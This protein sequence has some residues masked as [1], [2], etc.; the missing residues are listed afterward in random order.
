MLCN[1]L[2]TCEKLIRNDIFTNH[3]NFNASVGEFTDDF[4]ILLA[5]DLSFLHGDHSVSVLGYGG[6][7]F[8]TIGRVFIKFN[9]LQELLA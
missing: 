3:L 4:D 2:V 1:L 8:T 9:A 6:F 5:F 7:A